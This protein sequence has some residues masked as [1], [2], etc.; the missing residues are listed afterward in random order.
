MEVVKSFSAYSYTSIIGNI[1]EEYSYGKLPKYIESL[2]WNDYF[3]SKDWNQRKLVI[4][5][6]PDEGLLSSCDSWFGQANSV[7]KE[8]RS[9]K[10]SLML[11][12]GYEK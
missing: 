1:D 3:I 10:Y 6:K 11:Q 8:Q 4:K 5:T 9:K 12:L 7:L 2:G